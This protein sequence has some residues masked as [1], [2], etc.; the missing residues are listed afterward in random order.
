MIARQAPTNLLVSSPA[1]S[2]RRRI[3]AVLTTEFLFLLPIVI[4][5]MVA[6]VE[7]VFLINA[8]TK[9]TLAS[10]EG[11][12]VAAMGGST[13]DV[14]A[15]VTNVLGADVVAQSTIDVAYPNNDQTTG[16]PVQVTVSAP[17]KILVP[18]LVIGCFDPDTLQLTGLTTMVIE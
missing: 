2:N 7:F 15:A 3:G 11:A 5:L 10:R 17:A 1:R 14:Q 6:L 8:E 16:N 12:R 18:L 4:L 9:V 13:D